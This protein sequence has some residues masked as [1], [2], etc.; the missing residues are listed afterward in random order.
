MRTDSRRPLPVTAF[1]LGVI[2]IAGCA[3]NKGSA[4]ADDFEQEWCEPAHR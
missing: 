1:V 2:L 4:P 3:L